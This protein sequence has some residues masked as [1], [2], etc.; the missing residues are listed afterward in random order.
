MSSRYWWHWF[1]KEVASGPPPVPQFA[2]RID[3]IVARRRNNNRIRQLSFRVTDD[4]NIVSI[5]SVS[6]IIV[7]SNGLTRADHNNYSVSPALPASPVTFT[8]TAVGS[9]RAQATDDL[10]VGII[11][12]D[13]LG[14]QETLTQQVDFTL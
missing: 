12:R 9:L 8:A 6:F 14:R 7:Q 11:Y 2:G 4:N 3:N 13:E 5:V 1:P 10:R